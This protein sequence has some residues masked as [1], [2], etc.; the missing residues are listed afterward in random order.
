MEASAMLHRRV[1]AFAVTA[2]CLAVL[3]ASRGSL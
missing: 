3:G 1:S 2:V